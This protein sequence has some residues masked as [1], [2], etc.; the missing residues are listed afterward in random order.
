MQHGKDD[1]APRWAR[2][3]KFTLSPTGREAE[4]AYRAALLDARGAGRPALEAALAAWAAPHAPVAG[5]DGML[6][7]ELKGKPPGLADLTRALD[8][9]GIAPAEVRAALGR[10]VS[11]GLVALVPLASQQ[12]APERPPLSRW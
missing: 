12:A 11:A 5:G 9:A 1:A 3:Q 6:L 8:D 7:G 2:G 10:L 4:E